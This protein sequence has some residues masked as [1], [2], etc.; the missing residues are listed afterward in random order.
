[1]KNKKKF[2]K[3]AVKS[4]ISNA[5]VKRT[6]KELTSVGNEHTGEMERKRFKNLNTH[7]HCTHHNFHFKFDKM[8][9][10][11]FFLYFS[12]LLFKCY[13]HDLLF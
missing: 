10:L 11:Y 12:V 13:H 7:T 5:E 9:H 4:M 1:M 3:I 8:P 6:L 2:L